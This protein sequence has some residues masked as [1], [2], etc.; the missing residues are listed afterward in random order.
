MHSDSIVFFSSHGREEIY[1]IFAVI[2]SRKQAFS[3]SVPLAEV[4]AS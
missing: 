2:N 3:L 1:N 4:S